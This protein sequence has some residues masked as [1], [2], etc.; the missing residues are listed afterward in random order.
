MLQFLWTRISLKKC[1]KN[2][3]IQRFRNRIEEMLELSNTLNLTSYYWSHWHSMYRYKWES[4]NDLKTCKIFSY[5]KNIP[6]KNCTYPVQCHNTIIKTNFNTAW[7]SDCPHINLN[8]ENKIKHKQLVPT[9]DGAIPTPTTHVVR[10]H[11]P[12]KVGKIW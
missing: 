2:H 11:F 7:Q 6:I 9:S 3:K 5:P 10:D 1:G 8:S 4:W 12:E